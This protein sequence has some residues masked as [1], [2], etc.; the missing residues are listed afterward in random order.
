MRECEPY[1]SALSVLE[2]A[3]EQDMSN[4]FTRAGIINKFHLQ[5]RLALNLLRQMLVDEGNAAVAGSRA[6]SSSRR[7]V[8]S[9]AS[10][11]HCGWKCW[12]IIVALSARLVTRRSAG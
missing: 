9:I 12:R 3:P 5:M 8:A 4:A 2:Q 10:T 11:R 1:V 7:A 6:I